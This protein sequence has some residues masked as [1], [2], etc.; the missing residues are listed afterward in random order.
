MS[1]HIFA[2]NICGKTL[3]FKRQR[4]F[5]LMSAKL[6]KR[7]QEPIFKVLTDSKMSPKDIHSVV[8][9]G[10]STRIDFIKQIIMAMFST[11]KKCDKIDPD[12][13]VALGAGIQAN[14]LSDNVSH[15]LQ[16][17][18]LIDVTPFSLGVQG[19]GDDMIRII[20]R[21]ET[22]PVSKTRTF[23]T[24]EDDQ[25]RINIVVYQ[26]EDYYVTNCVCLGEFY[27]DNLPKV[28]KHK[29]NIDIKFNLDNN[30]I[31]DI[32]AREKTTG[33]SSQLQLK[34]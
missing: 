10:G 2:E 12:K 14:M 34:I 25:S 19:M 7:I 1:K 11:S 13:A 9:I 3:F 24:T 6:L 23:T 4:L 32:T 27:L 18:L 17:H 20:N 28:S 16:E 21:N 22:I 15:M 31:L 5:R 30:G 26:G 8:F 33:L 29:L